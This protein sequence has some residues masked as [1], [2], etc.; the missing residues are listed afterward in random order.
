MVAERRTTLLMHPLTILA[1]SAAAVTDVAAIRARH[2]VLGAVN[3]GLLVVGERNQ[4]I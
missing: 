3:S 1:E 2:C 4:V